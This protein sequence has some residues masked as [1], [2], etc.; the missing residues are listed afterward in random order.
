MDTPAEYAVVRLLRE[1]HMMIA[2]AES[3]TGGMIGSALV[4]VPGASYVYSDGFI[5]YSDSAKHR[6]L[7]VRQETLDRYSAVSE[8]TAREMAEG[9]A[10]RADADVG[11]SSTGIAGPDGGTPEKPVGLVWLGCTVRGKTTAEKHIFSG[12]RMAVRKQAAE[13]A[14]RLVLEC[15]ETEDP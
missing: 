1:K 13:R 8:Q 10:R 2:T 15:L 9:A 6:N 14:L 3:C 5:T 4:N 11:V 12:D 7:G